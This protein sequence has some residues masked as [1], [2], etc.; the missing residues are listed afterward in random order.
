MIDKQSW[1]QKKTV[2]NRTSFEGEHILWSRHATAKLIDLSISRI[3][4]EI[5]LEHCDLI[6][7]YADIHPPLPDC[8]VLGFLSSG[9]AIH[10]VVAI[11]KSNDRL[12][13]VTVYIPFSSRWQD[14]QRTRK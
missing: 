9:Q 7:D 5:A 3:D 8:L 2:Q 11:D 4:I 13:V 12:F 10:A 14:D 1:I 6:E